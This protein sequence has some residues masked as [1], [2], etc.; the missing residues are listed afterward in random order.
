MKTNNTILKEAAKR[1][2]ALLL[3][4]FMLFGFVP[5]IHIDESGKLDVELVQN[6]LLLTAE[7]E[8]I[9]IPGFSFTGL[10]ATA[11]TDNGGKTNDSFSGS[12]STITATVYA[13]ENVEKG[14]NSTTYSYTSRSASVFILNNSGSA[15]EV[16]Y[17]IAPVAGNSGSVSP[18]A[19]TYT[20]ILPA[21]NKLTVTISSGTK[22]GTNSAT[23]NPV[24]GKYTITINS[25]TVASYNVDVT[26]NPVAEINGMLPGSYTAKVGNSN[27]TIGETYNADVNTQYTLTAS[28]NTNFVFTGWYNN[29]TLLSTEKTVT[30]A[31]L[32]AS[33]SIEA[34]FELDPLFAIATLLESSSGETVY[35]Y[36]EINS[37]SYHSSKHSWHSD[38]NVGGPKDSILTTYFDDPTWS[39]KNNTI[40][41][42]TSGTATGDEASGAER[43]WSTV[44]IYSDIIRIKAKNDC[45]ISFKD[46]ITGNNLTSYNFYTHVASTALTGNPTTTIKT[47]ANQKTSGTTVEISL[48]AGNYLYILS[49]G[50]EHNSSLAS[51]R[52]VTYSYKSTI[53]N[54]TITPDNTRYQVNVSFE[55]NVGNTLA[56]GKVKIGDSVLTIGTNGVPSSPYEDVGG[57][58]LTL[59]VNTVPTNYVF[60]GW[61]DVTS[62]TT[63]YTSTYSIEL[64]GNKTIKAIFAP[65]M[66]ITS[67]GENGYGSAEYQYKNLSNVTVTADGQYVARNKAATVYYTSLSQAFSST[68]V[69]VLLAGDTFIGDFTVPEGKTLVV[70]CRMLDEGP[71][72][73]ALTD[74]STSISHYAVVTA[75]GNWTIDGSLIVSAT[76]GYSVHGRA[77]GSIGRFNLANGST[78]TVNGKLYAFGCVYGGT[79][80][81]GSSAE[82]YELISVGDMPNAV[83]MY[84]VDQQ[85]KSNKVFP[86]SNFFVSNIEAS[87]IYSSGAKLLGYVATQPAIAESY[88]QTTMPIIGSSGAM[89]QLTSGT[90]TKSYD[91]AKDQTVVSVDQ[92]ATVST[93][94]FSLTITLQAPMIG[95][96]TVN[97]NT[98]N[99]YLPLCSAYAIK[100]DGNLTV[101]NFYKLLPGALLDV[102]NTGSLTI[103]SGSELVLYRMN[104]YDGVTSDKFSVGGC[105]VNASR[106]PSPSSYN[107]HTRENTG[108]AK[109]NVDGTL[110]VEGGL[111][112]T[113][114]IVKQ[115]KVVDTPASGNNPEVYHYED[116]DYSNGY[117]YLT[118]VGTII[119]GN[120]NTNTTKI[121]ETKF[122][123]NSNDISSTEVSVTPI[124]GLTN[125]DATADNHNA[126]TEGDTEYSTLTKTAW[127]GYINDRNVNVWSTSLPATLTYDANNGTG[128]APNPVRKPAAMNTSIEVAT[129]TFTREGYEFVGWNTQADGNGLPYAVGA[130]VTLSADTTLYA[131]WAEMFT[132]TFNMQSH[133]D[134]INP[135]TDIVSGSTITAPGAPSATGYTF[136][137]WYKDAACTNEWNF[138][139][140]TVTEDTELFAK[141]TANTYTIIWKNAD[142]TVL[143]T[144]TNVAYGTTPTYDGAT[145]TKA[146]DAQYSYTFSGWSPAVSAVTGDMT[147]TATF[148][149]TVNKYTVTWKN[150]DGTVLE[151]A[152]NVPYG[153]TPTYNSATPTKAGDAQYSYT[154]SGWTPT[155]SAVTGN[156]TYTATFTQSVNQYTVTWK[157]HDGT[158]LETVE[159]V[160]YGT[161]P[162]YNSAT[163]TK[164]SDAQY[165]YSFSGWT[166]AIAAVTADA[167]YTASY[168]SETRDYTLVINYLKSDVSGEAAWS[169]NRTYQYNGNV[170]APVYQYYTFSGWSFN[171]NDYL[172]DPAG[173]YGTEQEATNALKGALDEYLVENL[174]T[175]SF[176]VTAHYTR[177]KFSLQLYIELGDGEQVNSGVMTKSLG[178]PLRVTAPDPYSYGGT[179]HTF[180][181]WEIKQ[182]NTPIEYSSNKKVTFQP[183]NSGTY[184]AIAHYDVDSSNLPIELRDVSISI[185]RINFMEYYENETRMGVTMLIS[186][187]DDS[188]TEIN[189]IGFLY[190]TK[191]AQYD[192][193]ISKE[194]IDGIGSF[195][196]GNQELL[197]M[198][199]GTYTKRFTVS[200][201]NPSYYI[202]GYV[203]Y[204]DSTGSHYLFTTYKDHKMY[205]ES[206]PAN[207]YDIVQMT[208]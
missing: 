104:D 206:I 112:V 111:Y 144:D 123:P 189:E 15:L 109:M 159:N 170:E 52:R 126:P 200:S 31:F 162:T 142:G 77:V 58:E 174:Q 82:V 44:N 113:N 130:S 134:P 64:N 78:M 83:Q 110:S 145:P 186:M 184:T 93:G 98:S 16:I 34:R 63:S 177:Q 28:N 187:N 2:F 199:N 3:V 161:T 101:N 21:G 135:I 136:G 198:K 4:L 35:D 71:T 46:T 6:P 180:S 103:S 84:Y 119:L 151:T 74:K 100:V 167:T 32:D 40:E 121:Y 19:G 106:F 1:A 197:A 194:T 90:M 33:N 190:S 188:I 120:A 133:G 108:S 87:V 89:F 76:Q 13:K 99:Y 80:S 193:A 154:F 39:K 131:Q 191:T 204:T 165:T 146:G 153:T 172:V 127:Y 178:I 181:Y 36:V 73:P 139:T 75:N 53:S 129:N 148:T 96:Q 155:V 102:G 5:E 147:Y 50:Y 125:W 117:N 97:I 54:F 45:K 86:F 17:S 9:T 195:K 29:N 14:C 10:S 41:S 38:T 61:R 201:T 183:T 137:G 185:S 91:R 150:H 169:C 124:M 107:A 158:V 118:G 68:D 205:S 37:A 70:P 56:S 12:G 140:D 20:E 48:K 207:N 173:T 128:T 85:L 196:S 7:A 27:R 49:Y 166:P 115:K 43:S 60:V 51:T 152:S 62:E 203:K 138:S 22:D 11:N 182:G 79:I 69:V 202:V 95:S 176:S 122:I 168:T 42:A 156:A 55:D 92:G 26:F 143:E 94:A 88:C 66:T 171:G 24:P 175:E 67:G 47:E 160:A 141:W 105:P 18:S 192:N 57:S 59:S 116:S 157:N 208:N 72:V 132:V 149:Q 163:P 81:T 179:S 164:A 114:D 30:M 8:E 23:Q 25:A 65:V